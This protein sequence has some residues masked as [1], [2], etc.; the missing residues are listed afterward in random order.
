MT[1]TYADIERD[2]IE[3][4]V[5]SVALD[6]RI[7]T[8]IMYRRWY[9]SERAAGWPKPDNETLNIAALIEL[10]ALRRAAKRALAR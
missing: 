4:H 7:R 1:T 9:R 6:E 10:L 3:V 8:R 5:L 2:A